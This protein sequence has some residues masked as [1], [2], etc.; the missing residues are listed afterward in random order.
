MQKKDRQKKVHKYVNWMWVSRMKLMC[1]RLSMKP[2]HTGHGLH[3]KRVPYIFGSD[4]G[5][6]AGKISDMF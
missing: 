2:V 4:S 1:D 5:A 6:N 3:S